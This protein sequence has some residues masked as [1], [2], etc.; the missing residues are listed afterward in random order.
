MIEKEY[1]ELYQT[2]L[3][4]A[5]EA[6]NFF[7]IRNLKKALIADVCADCMYALQSGEAT[8]DELMDEYSVA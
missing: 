8:L 5:E 6:C 2:I 4:W 7:N 3:W 1:P